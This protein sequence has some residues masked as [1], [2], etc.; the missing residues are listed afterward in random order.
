MMKRALIFVHKWLGI[1]LALPFL[2][3]FISGIVLYYVPFPNLTQEERLSGLP[4]LQ[5]GQKDC[6]LTA[7]QAASQANVTFTEARF[8]MQGSQPVWRLLTK[9]PDQQW[10]AVDARLGSMLPPLSEA[11]AVRLAEVYSQ[12]RAL[13]AEV[14]DR[15]QWTV[16]QGLNPYRPLVKVALD[17]PD[18]L[19]LYVSSGAAEVVR[20]TRRSER[21]WNWIGAVPH[22]IYFTE[23]RRWPDT[24]HHVVVWLA[25]PGTLLALTGV[26]IGIWHLFL[27][28]SRWIPYRKLWMRWHHMLG[29]AAGI[30]TVTWIF[31]G[32][33][34]MNPFGIFSSRAATA[35]ERAQWSGPDAVAV[36]NPAA[37]LQLAQH[38]Q[39]REIDL[40]RF[41]G[42]VWYRL[43]GA[44]DN[45]SASA[46][47]TLG[48]LLIRADG[49]AAQPLSAFPDPAIRNMLAG[50]RGNEVSDIPLI[51]RLNDYD[52]LY[53]THPRSSGA[54]YTHPLPV[55]RAEWADGI[56]IYADPASAR[57][58]LRVDA[59]NR[60]QRVLYNGL[61]SF[62]FAPLLAFPTLRE[63]LI[64]LLLL[65]GIALSLT[66]CVI[67]WRSVKL[68][69]R[70]AL[71]A[72]DESRESYGD[73][74]RSRCLVETEHLGKGNPHA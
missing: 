18:G 64:L 52:N 65:L 37:A 45:D 11:E 73:R 40:I 56:V 5:V 70:K 44:P 71:T 32:L 9:K 17:G 23:L 58:M 15:D 13:H 27:N 43:R 1:A 62:D 57:I 51:T 20:D 31:S 48:H 54:R 47:R 34:S 61:H 21:F 67:A 26:V 68:K 35:G 30:V 74:V 69:A 63:A 29:L 25:L 14:L 28:R 2:M 36:L 53:Y 3:W 19:E 42:G 6:C 50:I 72:L 59:S 38:M 41:N 16:A 66:S 7:Q 60:W 10:R 8:G 55:L 33:L 49:R 12:R 46:A 24:W 4:P 39:A 22:W